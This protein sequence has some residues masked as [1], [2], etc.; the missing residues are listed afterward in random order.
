MKRNEKLSVESQEYQA[1]KR[2]GKGKKDGREPVTRATPVKGEMCEKTRPKTGWFLKFTRGSGREENRRGPEHR[3][4]GGREGQGRK[5]GAWGDW[6]KKE[7]TIVGGNQQ[8]PSGITEAGGSEARLGCGTRGNWG[9]AHRLRE[10]GGEVDSK[11]ATKKKE[12]GRGEN[13]FKWGGHGKRSFLQKMLKKRK[14]VRG[15]FLGVSGWGGRGLKKNPQER[16][17]VRLF[18]SHG[19]KGRDGGDRRCRSHGGGSRRSLELRDLKY[20]ESLSGNGG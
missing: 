1:K 15:L 16:R 13:A 4:R 7:R 11:A 20:F 19:G 17:S 8:G 14:E 3:G 10:C 18:R 2:K 5:K 6:K 9:A 12:K